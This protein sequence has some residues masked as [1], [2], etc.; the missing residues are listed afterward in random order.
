MLSQAIIKSGESG[1][2]GIATDWNELGL[3]PFD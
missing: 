1:M 2:V 3:K